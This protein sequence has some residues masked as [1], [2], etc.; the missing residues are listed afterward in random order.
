MSMKNEKQQVIV[1]VQHNK[2]KY[3]LQLISIHDFYFVFRVTIWRHT[4]IFSSLK[5]YYLSQSRMLVT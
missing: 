4:D 5:K 1:T 3:V 2:F